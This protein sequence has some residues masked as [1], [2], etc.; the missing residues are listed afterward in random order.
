[1][2]AEFPAVNFNILKL[3]YF[4]IIHKL[5]AKNI[6]RF[7]YNDWHRGRNGT[8]PVILTDKK[9]VFGSK[10]RNGTN[11]ANQSYTNQKTNNSK[12]KK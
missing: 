4:Y 2:P 3:I 1:M 8:P 9:S 7:I 10:N 6:C 11:I 5:K 12:L